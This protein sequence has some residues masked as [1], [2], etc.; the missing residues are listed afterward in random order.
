[1]SSIGPSAGS[2]VVATARS[3]VTVM[4]SCGKFIVSQQWSATADVVVVVLLLGNV[5]CVVECPL[6]QLSS[7]SFSLISL[8][9]LCA[10]TKWL[11]SRLELGGRYED[12]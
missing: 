12:M 7:T 9:P 5:C 3:G 2:G 6:M 11:R 10:V 4:D 8:S 1:M